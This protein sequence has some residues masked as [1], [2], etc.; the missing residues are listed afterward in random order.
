MW[1]EE[2]RLGNPAS[3][4]GSL[5]ES[6]GTLWPAQRSPTHRTSVWTQRQR[7][8]PQSLRPFLISLLSPI[9]YKEQQK[10]GL[11]I[12]RAVGTAKCEGTSSWG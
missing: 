8:A 5:G 4:Q 9:H 12:C 11:P 2:P 3:E 10:P 7:S 1:T 6:G